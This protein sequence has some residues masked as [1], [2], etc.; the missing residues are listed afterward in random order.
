LIVGVFF[1]APDFSAAQVVVPPGSEIPIP[2]KTSNDS[3]QVV[4]ADTIQAPFGRSRAPRTADI[5]PQY[6]WNREEMFASGALTVSDLLERVPGVT[7]FRTG[8]LA[9]PKFAAVNGDLD[10]IQVYYDGIEIDNLDPRSGQLLDLTTIE[11]WS[12]ESVQIERAAN[13]IRVHLRS[14]RVDRTAPYT[15]TDIFTGDEDTQI[16][17]GYYGKRFGNGSGLQLGGEHYSTR[18]SRLGGGGDALSFMGRFG[19]ARRMWSI[20]AYALRRGASRTLQP[21]FSTTGGLSIPA[22]D[23][24]HSITYLRGAIGNP[25]GGGWA[26]VVAS[27]TRFSDRSVFVTP[28]EALAQRLVA[29]T[30][31]TSVSRF[32]YL[33]TAGFSRGPVRLSVEDRVRAFDDE[34]FHSPA[35]RAEVGGKFG[36]ASLYAESN[37]LTRANRADVIGRL[38]PLP[39][40]AVAGAFSVSEPH[41]STEI[42]APLPWN[43]ARLEVG[44]RLINPW[45]I[46]GFIT[47]DTAVLVGPVFV[48]T[49]YQ[50]VS[51]GRRQGLYGGLRGSIYKD[52]YVDVVGT[53]WDSA[54]FYQPRYQARSEI[55]VNTRW[56]SRF[57]SGNFGLKAAFIYDYRGRVTFPTPGGT[58]IAAGSGVM[59][60]LLEIR[61]RNGV[62]S[63]QIRNIAGTNY[64]IFPDFFMP[65]SINIYGIRWEFWN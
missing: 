39:F 40:L 12:L 48:D 17:R 27:N 52:L 3:P 62:A 7:G 21:T 35:V 65:R 37:S 32:Q 15:R 57:R 55:F 16:Y 38:T 19:I 44:L 22:Y 30:S 54:G 29:D 50:A 9:S 45:L 11:L 24:T 25:A 41:D 33:G 46:G 60:G 4:R 63:Y 2:P 51:I 42:T 59:N 10:R 56:I 13:G 18:A 49:A 61:I 14:W 28:G 1:F 34:I 23:G 53:R 36:I 6:Q 31:D 64:Q 20:D 47:R 26:E 8:W 5:G 58:R 43:A